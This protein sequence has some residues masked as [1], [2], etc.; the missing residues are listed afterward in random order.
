MLMT[1]CQSGIDVELKAIDGKLFIQHGFDLT[2]LEVELSSFSVTRKGCEKVECIFNSWEWK[3]GKKHLHIE[4][5]LFEYKEIKISKVEFPYKPLVTGKYNLFGSINLKS[6]K[7]GKI[8]G[9]KY[10]ALDFEVVV[11]SSGR[12]V[13][14]KY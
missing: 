3:D 9:G 7:T 5:E 13:E 2:K 12:V 6:K 4:S 1:S 14:V 8:K 11:D 10:F